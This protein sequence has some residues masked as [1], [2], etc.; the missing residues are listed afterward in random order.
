[1]DRTVGTLELFRGQRPFDAGER[2]LARLATDQ[3]GVAL[4]SLAGSNGAAAH[5]TAFADVLE[6]AGDA[7]AAGSDESRTADQIALLAAEATGALGAVVWTVEDNRS[8]SPLATYRVPD[9]AD[10]L[11]GARAVARRAV[12]GPRPVVSE[13]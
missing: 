6:L 5:E 12:L 7:L 9:E 11:D 10:A 3:L 2:L 4:R 13:Q 8:L 1:G